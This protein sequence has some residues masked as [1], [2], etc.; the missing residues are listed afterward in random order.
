M[1]EVEEV[2]V[3]P[4]D[5]SSAAS[6]AA[7]RPQPQRVRR[8]FYQNPT[9]AMLSIFIKGATADDVVVVF[10]QTRLIVQLRRTVLGDAY[11]EAEAEAA[12]PSGMQTV[13]DVA[14]AGTIDPSRS[15]Y[16]VKS[17]KVEVKM[18]KLGA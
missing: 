9:H 7:P 8:D 10:T 18:A 17:M 14:L 15:S 11:A 16:K 6:I 5:A 3:V 4:A 13:V 2:D 12:D 1:P